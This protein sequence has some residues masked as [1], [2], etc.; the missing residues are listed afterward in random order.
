[1]DLSPVSRDPMRAPASLALLIGSFVVAFLINLLPWNGA[2]LLV[3][4]DVVLLVVLYWAV[5]ES[6]AVGQ[7]MAFMLGLL[8]DVADSVL[9]GQHA[10][11]YVAAVFLVQLLRFR[12]LQ[13]GVFERALH[14]LAVLVIA[15]LL[16]LLL[17]ASV[18]RAFAGWLVFVSPVLTAL[19]WPLADSLARSPRFNRRSGRIVS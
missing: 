16:S 18:G 13:M 6:R 10:L 11:V 4:P 17:N 14:A 19:L 15:Q 8:M 9:L 3:R 5:H 12:M 7:G 2:W 1:M